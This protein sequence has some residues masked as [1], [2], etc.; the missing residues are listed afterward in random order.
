M[1]LL[2]SLLLNAGLTA[3]EL[4]ILTNAVRLP[5]G[6]GQFEVLVPSN[7][8]YTLLISSDLK[9]WS[10]GMTL[11]GPTNRFVI[12]SPVPMSQMG[13]VFLRAAVGRIPI[14]SA[15][16]MFFADAGSFAGSTN[17]TASFPAAIRDYR[18][19]MDVENAPVF[20]ER[21]NVAFT[22]PSGSGLISS[23]AEMA[24]YDPN[25]LYASYGSPEV[26]FAA[27]AL[28]GTWTVKYGST[29]LSFVLPDPQAQARLVVPT[30]RVV[31]SNNVVTS[32]RWVY[33]DAATG[34][35]L[36]GPPAFLSRVK[37]EIDTGDQFSSVR[38][39]DSPELDPGTTTHVLTST[40]LWNQVVRI[41]MTYDDTL[42]NHYVLFF[43]Q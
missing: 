25:E 15:W 40:I 35:A 33:R 28:G 4:P 16:L 38:A 32:V 41:N 43:Q 2:L 20:V 22:G 30:P 6:R 26:T 42:N 11:E 36:S 7:G 3:A 1:L 12:T 39:Y 31:V 21:T 37:V 10:D 23:M 13:N 24:E 14:Y 18:A 34:Q 9:T 17:A 19:V 29:N 27:M 5:D 8:V